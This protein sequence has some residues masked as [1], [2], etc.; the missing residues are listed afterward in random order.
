MMANPLLATLMIDGGNFY[1]KLRSLHLSHLLDFNYAAFAAFLAED[2]T[3]VE[4]RYYIGAIRDT[5]DTKS[6]QLHQDQ[7]RLLSNLKRYG[8]AYS[9][10]YLLKDQNGVYKEK[11]V[12]VQMA[13][14]IVRAAY[15]QTCDRI[16]LISSDTDLI[17]AIEIA[18]SK[19]VEIVYVGFKHQQSYALKAKASRYRLLT[20]DHLLPFI[21]SP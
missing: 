19:G 18:R 13:V 20:K 7:Q 14:D 6:Q 11:G 12:D 1:H 9:L 5:K 2:A 3:L 21:V 4:S 10:G 16:L 8:F 15:E 17:P